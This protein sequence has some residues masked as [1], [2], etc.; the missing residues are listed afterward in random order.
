MRPVFCR[1][2]NRCWGAAGDPVPSA[3]FRSRSGLHD[4]AAKVVPGNRASDSKKAAMFNI[5]R[6]NSRVMDF[7]ECLGISR[8][9]SALTQ[10]AT[11]L[12]VF[13]PMIVAVGAV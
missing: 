10:I 9:A 8:F 7:D 1:S 13:E 12:V 5:S 3:V 2:S 6:I 11:L 4:L